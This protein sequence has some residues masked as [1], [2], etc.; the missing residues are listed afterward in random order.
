MNSHIDGRKIRDAAL[1]NNP[2]AQTRSADF[3]T[4]PIATVVKLTGIDFLVRFDRI[5]EDEIV[6]KT[7]AARENQ[8]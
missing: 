8:Q 6:S 3:A 2:N 1:N 7:H 4:L 5:I